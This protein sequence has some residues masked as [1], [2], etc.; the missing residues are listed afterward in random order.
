MQTGVS[1]TAI[2]V[3][4]IAERMEC[5]ESS[6]LC[7][8]RKQS[9]EDSQH[10]IRWRALGKRIKPK[11]IGINPLYPRHPR[12]MNPYIR[13]ISALGSQNNEGARY[14]H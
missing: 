13:L 14:K 4:E 8:S 12:S 5:C 9:C 3:T 7:V 10:S 1:K 2:A 6:Q 11:K